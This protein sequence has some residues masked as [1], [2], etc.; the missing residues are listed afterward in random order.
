MALTILDSSIVIGLLDRSDQLH[1]AATAAMLAHAGDD[2]RLPA[3]AYAE[4]LVG[5]ARR[6]RLVDARARVSDLQLEIEPLTSTIA[7]QAAQ[8]RS[9]FRSLRLPDVLVIATAEVL[10]ADTI[11]TG[12]AAWR[13]ASPRVVLVS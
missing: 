4:C 2:L 6:G 1:Q 13:R 9:R 8:L 7:E 10:K 11:L 5:P 3:S 12:D